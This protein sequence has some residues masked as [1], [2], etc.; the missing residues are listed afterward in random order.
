MTGPAAE[1]PD[2]SALRRRLRAQRRALGPA[3]R[4]QAAFDLV[5]I[6]ATLPGWAEVDRLAGY[7]AIGGELPLIGLFGRGLSAGFHLPCLHEDGVLRFARWSPGDALRD[8][9]VGL[10]EPAVPESGLLRPEAMDLVLLP[11]LGFTRSGHRLGQGGG[12]YDRSFAFLSNAPRPSRP[13]LVGV[14]Y[15]LQEVPEFEPDAWDVA[16]DY[17]ATERELIPCAAL[18]NEPPAAT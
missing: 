3:E 5:E 9:S 4:M 12:W 14:G 7:W 18:R 13:L 11:L 6:L 10:P 2:K 16:L 17:V 8:S 15:G 1:S